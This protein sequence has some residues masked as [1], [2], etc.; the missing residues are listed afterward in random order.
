MTITRD[1]AAFLTN[2]ETSDLSDQSLDHGAML[3]ASTIASAAAG[4]DIRS[5]VIIRDLARERGG[6][7]DATVW[8]DAGPKLPVVSAARANALMS[9]AAASDDSDLRNITHMGTPLTAASLATA[10][11]TGANGAEVLTAIVLG[12]GAAGR[13]GASITPEF[14]KRGFH[15]CVVAIFS[16]AVATGRLLKLDAN[17]MTHA[18]ALSATSIGGLI[19]A[20]D[21]SISREYHAGLATMLGIEAAQAAQRG[22]TGEPE[23]LEMPT[24]FC[25]IYGGTSGADIIE[26][27]GQD[28]DIV[29]D[30]AIK[31]APGGHF[32][33]AMAEAAGN[34]ARIGDI[35]PDNIASITLSRP[36][37][38]ELS[39]VL[40][41][42]TL[43]DMAHSAAYFI[44]A[45]AVDRDFS[46]A[47]AT[48]EKIADP[49]IHR[50][51][52]KIRVG[53]PPTE[54]I[55]AY[56]QGAT[57][58]IE[59]I[60][61]RSVTETVL[62]PNGAGY[63]GIDWVDINAKYHALAPT[64]MTGERV[65]SSLSVIR[66]FKNLSNVSELTRTLS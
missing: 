60:D 29:T 9:D 5:A 31:L 65:E 58:T 2:A 26:N 49:V 34:A 43:I 7:A 25:A 16:S 3:I 47:H 45:G 48:P 19:A 66:N 46:W 17:Q 39:G 62:A 4:T 50:V 30:L 63:R 54:N 51:I 59:T 21:T 44:A 6:R 24:G 61:G 23:I 14:R 36:N 32:Y 41:P 22:Y 13:I 10:E 18:I 37:T 56:R 12:Y 15:A 20:A 33:H 53:A 28:W 38:T 11:L 8:F 40:H 64:A 35:A 52:D 1:L 42:E 27:M 55:S 57:V